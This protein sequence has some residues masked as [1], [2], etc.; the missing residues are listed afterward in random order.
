M[1]ALIPCTP[2]GIIEIIDK[3][4]IAGADIRAERDD[5]NNVFNFN[6]FFTCWL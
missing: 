5:I 4:V 2:Q 1:D 3:Y 6:V